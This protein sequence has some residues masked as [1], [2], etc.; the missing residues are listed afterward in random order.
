MSCEFLI[1]SGAQVNTLTEKSFKELHDNQLYREGLYNIEVRSDRSLKAYASAGEIKVLYTFEAFLYVSEDRPILLEKFYVVKECRSL[2]GRQTATR[3]NVLLLGLQV[4][5]SLENARFPLRNAARDIAMVDAN[6]AFPKFNISP[7]EISYDK[8]RSPCRNIFMNI[9]PAIRPL[10]EQRLQHLMSEN[11]IERVTEDMDTSFCSSMLVVPKGRDDFRLVIDLRGPNRYINRTPFSMP[12]LEKILV[13]LNGSNWFSTID[14]SNAF[15]HI[16]LHEN[17][18]HLTNFFTEF[19]MFRYVRLPFGLC[20]APDIFQEVLQRK[21]L[22]ACKGVKNYLD[23]IIV[24]GETKEE[25]DTNLAAVLACL[26]EH[27]VKINTSKCVFASQSVK[28]L[29]Y[30]LTPSGWQIEDGKLTAIQ[31]FRRPETCS[32]V[33]SFLGLITYIDKFILD[34]ATKT[35]RLRTLANADVFYWTLKEEQEFVSLQNGAVNAIKKLGYFCA[36]DRT[37]LFVDASA[38]GLGAVLIQ[39]NRD[40]VPRIIAC[41]SKSLTTTEQKYPQTHKEALA[42]VWGVERFTFYLTGNM[43]LNFI[44]AY[45]SILTII[46]PHVRNFFCRPNGFRG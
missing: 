24:H 28:F 22:G 25:H 31:N 7:V 39:F 13:D 44:N 21:I 40:D 16:E 19:G 5:V 1:D 14:L 29:G 42:V 37:E 11:I 33:K 36:T 8:T 20:N 35:E 46:F 41:A 17:S 23:D 3:Y 26:E 30:I 32:E 12:T 43:N 34:R 2:L 4:P 9:P 45:M 6:E 18:R 15:F 10:V 27:N 38:I